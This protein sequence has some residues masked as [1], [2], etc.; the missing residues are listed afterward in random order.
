MIGKNSKERLKVFHFTFLH[1]N[2]V[3]GHMVFFVSISIIRETKFYYSFLWL[4]LTLFYIILN[5]NTP[6]VCKGIQVKAKNVRMSEVSVKHVYWL[7]HLKRQGSANEFHSDFG[8]SYA[9]FHS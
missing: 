6:T 3:I 2:P 9:L 7:S 4:F 1:E 5:L 8:H